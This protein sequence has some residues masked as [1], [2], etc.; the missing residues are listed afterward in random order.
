MERSL[1]GDCEFH[2]PVRDGRLPLPLCHEAH[3]QI[4]KQ[5]SN[6]DTSSDPNY[7]VIGKIR[8]ETTNSWTNLRKACL[9]MIGAEVM[10]AGAH[11]LLL[12]KW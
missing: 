12:V 6:S 4:E 7:P 3:D 5:Q 9:D 10:Y 1:E 2:H 11:G 8:A